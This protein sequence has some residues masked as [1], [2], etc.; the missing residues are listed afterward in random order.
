MRVPALLLFVALLWA[1]RISAQ[2]I[3]ADRTKSKI[4]SREPT[5]IKLVTKKP[6]A[7]AAAKKVD[8]APL[9]VFKRTPCF[10]TC[11][12]YEATIYADGR[13][14]YTGYGYVQRTGT[15]ELKLPQ[16]VVSTI[17]DDA[18]RLNFSTYEDRYSQGSTD[19]PTT[20]LSIRQPNGQVKTVQAEEGT[21]A[22]LEALL[23]YISTEIEKVSG[24]T[25]T[26]DR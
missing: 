12:H 7:N 20:V 23:Q 21:P 15:H 11:P 18:R 16:R 4:V 5:K 10:G 19:L 1:D 17:L 9:I 25:S 2:N 14:S 6:A 26:T 13:V 3:A 22:E 24:G 8:S